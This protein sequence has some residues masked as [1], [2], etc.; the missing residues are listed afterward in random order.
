MF[1][2]NFGAGAGSIIP[3]KAVSA[4]GNVADALAVDVVPELACRTLF[5][6]VTLELGSAHAFIHIPDIS[7]SAAL[8]QTF[9]RTEVRPTKLRSPK[10]IIHHRNRLTLT[11]RIIPFELL[12]TS[13][14]T[15]ALTTTIILVPDLPRLTEPHPG[16]I[17]IRAPFIPFQPAGNLAR[18]GALAQRIRMN[19]LSFRA[20]G[21]TIKF[22]HA[23]ALVW[24]PQVV[25]L[26]VGCQ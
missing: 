22:G 7:D 16:R 2:A 11:I 25:W 23:F 5:P 21:R 3:G 17:P 13:S 4:E 1:G 20:A 10:E 14:L 8:F 12:R 26:A 19:E 15:P 18:I 24:V 6:V 9:S